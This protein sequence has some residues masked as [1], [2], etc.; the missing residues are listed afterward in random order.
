MTAAA[1]SPA[2]AA[3]DPGGGRHRLRPS[4]EVFPASTGDIYLLQPGRRSDL[5]VRSPD[6]A[7]RAMLALLAATAWSTAE[8]QSELERQTIT[9]DRDALEGKLAA[10]AR[11]GALRTVRGD[12]APLQP[13]DAERFDRQ[14]P[15]F[16]ETGDPLEAQHALRA[17]TVVVLGCG[18][19][20]TW[21][22][23]ALASAGV[24][25][26]V[27][28]DDDRIELSNLNRQVLYDVDDLGAAKVERAA[29]WVRRFDPRIAV[30]PLRRRVRSPQDLAPVL[31]G[32]DVVVLAADWP[33]YELVRWVNEACVGAE[34]PYVVAGQ[35]PPVLKVGPTYAPGRTACYACHERA[36]RRDFPLYEELTRHHR[37]DPRPATTLGPASAVVGALLALEVMHLL[38]GDVAP[39]TTGR[40]LLIDMR[41]LE[42]R[43]EE[44][45]RDP[46][47]P[48]CH[49]L[50]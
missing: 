20:G 9:L 48:S 34:V 3:G 7:D 41:T 40:A 2:A 46:D 17:A 24:G 27:L 4:I 5:V 18:G 37:D 45:E 35:V 21:A 47:C 28:I 29:A 50:A 32:A 1:G 11:V 44:V 6:A 31:E 36:L 39:A 33:P 15:Y 43:W 26:F 25:R 14:L 10:L 38:A 13:G 22:L 42:T 16:A 19:L 30:D 23:G 12:T 49:H 8:L